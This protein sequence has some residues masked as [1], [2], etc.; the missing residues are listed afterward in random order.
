MFCLNPH[1]LLS[2]AIITGTI[3][4]EMPENFLLL[5]LEVEVF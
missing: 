5:Q 2:K 3:Y 4:L 1:N